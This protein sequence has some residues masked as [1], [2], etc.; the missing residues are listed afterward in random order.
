MD[1]EVYVKESSNCSDYWKSIKVF[2]PDETIVKLMDRYFE[3]KSKHERS[4]NND[5]R[6]VNT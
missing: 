4:E 5:S 3:I 2:I 1:V 6:R